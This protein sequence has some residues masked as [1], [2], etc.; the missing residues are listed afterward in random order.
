MGIRAMP[1]LIRQNN[2]HIV[3]V[4]HDNTKYLP[5]EL[6]T[7]I[8]S[9]LAPCFAKAI[10]SQY[11]AH[12]LGHQLT[13]DEPEPITMQAPPLPPSKITCTRDLKHNQLHII[14]E[15]GGVLNIYRK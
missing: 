10:A 15:S 8:R 3:N 13:A 9:Q 2:G 12:I 7:Q 11:T 14:V 1:D 4:W 6:A 5:H